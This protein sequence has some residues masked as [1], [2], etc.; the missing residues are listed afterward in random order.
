MKATKE[1]IRT[2]TTTIYYEFPDSC[3]V[4]DIYGWLEDRSESEDDYMV[5]EDVKDHLEGGNIVFET[6]GKN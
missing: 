6:G 1:I 2:Y 5:E 3:D 4:N